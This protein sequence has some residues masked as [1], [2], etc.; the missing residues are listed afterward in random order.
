MIHRQNYYF[1]Q[2]TKHL[3]VVAITLMPVLS[4]ML[5]ASM[6]S[7]RPLFKSMER[8]V[9]VG[10]GHLRPLHYLQTALLRAA[11]PPHDYLSHRNGSEKIEWKRFKTVVEDAFDDA[12]G[13]SDSE[14]N[15]Q[16][17]NHLRD[18][19]SDIRVQGDMLFPGQSGIAGQG[20]ADMM[21]KFD[22]SIAQLS[23]Q[24]RL[25]IQAMDD[26][27]SSEYFL[28]EKR[29]QH[30]I[31]IF[32]SAVS[33]GLILGVC[34][35]ILLTRSRKK[36]VKLS[37]I[38]DLTGIYNRRGLEKAFK[39]LHNYR[40]ANPPV[41]FSILLMD[42]DKFKSI[43]D[44]FGHDVGDL[45]LKALADQTRKMIRSKDVFGRFGGEEFLVL[46]PET[47]SEEARILAERI[48]KGIASAAIELPGQGEAISVTVSI[49]CATSDGSSDV[50]PVLKAADKAMYQAKANGRNRVV[51]NG[52]NELR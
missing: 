30:G 24:I 36:I 3:I 42:L 43:N 17:L 1:S 34:G 14:S 50:D 28:I 21:D 33:L 6:T 8:I 7:F 37:Q 4:F 12:I 26:S 41:G 45:A 29:K 5:I 23:D 16:A 18:R 19:W 38:D 22:A 2:R 39:R 27:I 13:S 49:G 9:Y 40:L 11:M 31:I 10:Y 52:S 15:R 32:F 35:S 25:Q 48:R 20:Q 46:L 51:C 47:T 44:R